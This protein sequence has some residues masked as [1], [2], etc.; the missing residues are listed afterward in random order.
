MVTVNNL[1]TASPNC[2][3]TETNPKEKCDLKTR[4]K[5]ENLNM[6]FP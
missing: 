2:D 5:D 6:R 3:F 4:V 1:P